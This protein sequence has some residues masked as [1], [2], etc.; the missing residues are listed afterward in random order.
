MAFTSKGDG[1]T[2]S[3]NL[4][5]DG[6]LDNTMDGILWNAA[7]PAT[8]EMGM[9]RHIQISSWNFDGLIDEA[10]LWTR[11]LPATG[12]ES[13]A[14]LYNS[15]APT[16]LSDT[17]SS[18]IR[19]WWRMGDASGDDFTTGIL[20][21]VIGTS[22]MTLSN[23]DISNRGTDIPETY[24]LAGSGLS[25][26]DIQDE[27]PIIYIDTQAGGP[28]FAAPTIVTP[29]QIP[30][31]NPVPLPSSSSPSSGPI[32]GGT[33]ITISGTNFVGVS[34]VT[35][36]GHPCT[37]VDNVSSTT[38]TAV[39]PA[40]T[41]GDKDIIITGSGGSGTLT[42]AFTYMFDTYSTEFDGI[43]ESASS[44]T[45]IFG[46]AGAYSY[47]CW[48]KIASIPATYGTVGHIA[49]AQWNFGRFWANI[50]AG[51]SGNV[52]QVRE[53]NTDGSQGSASSGSPYLALDT[54]YHLALTSKGDGTTDSLNIYVD[55]ALRGTSDGVAWSATVPYGTLKMK[56]GE[57]INV[58]NWALDGLIDE[59][60]FWTR[61]LPPTGSESIESL[62]NLGVPTDLSV[63]HSTSLRNWWRMGDAPGDNFTTGI[64]EDVVG[65]S[66][67]TLTAMDASNKATNAPS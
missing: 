11:E 46:T 18:G 39:T 43:D 37:S 60:A 22:D 27:I 51:S 25:A 28:Y 45:D 42:D 29:I 21:D 63:T 5:I 31:V 56:I 38:V 50:Y 58:T 8:S 10:A 34:A 1:T 66:D 62:Y 17:H 67:L 32:F 53:L 64:L 52:F 16:D 55:G 3:V 54:W 33:T 48:V 12:D 47:S 61:V 14:S 9:G 59:C 35:V 2:D 41:A 44:T 13:V 65:T 20:E 4:Y 6:A 40:G 23:M 19:N 26:S 57:A 7:T 36:G 24:T 49:Y 30:Y 15:G